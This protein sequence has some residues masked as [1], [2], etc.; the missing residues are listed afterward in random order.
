MDPTH[1]EKG[2][3]INSQPDYKFLRLATNPWWGLLKGD[4]MQAFRF[5]N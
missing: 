4:S 1:L 2:I 3:R 5:L